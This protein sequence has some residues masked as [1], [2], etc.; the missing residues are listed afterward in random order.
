MSEYRDEVSVMED[1]QAARDALTDAYEELFQLSGAAKQMGNFYVAN[2]L[3]RVATNIRRSQTALQKL[4]GER[5][6]MAFERAEKNS[7]NLL[8][9]ALAGAQRAG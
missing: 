4:E 2:T 8:E 3:H 9:A 7:A 1:E 5:S 6:R